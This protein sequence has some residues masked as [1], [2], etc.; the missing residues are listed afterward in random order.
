MADERAAGPATA[1]WERT[2]PF[3]GRSA[4][5]WGNG[6][7]EGGERL[8]LQCDRG[9]SARAQTR[10]C[11]APHAPGGGSPVRLSFMPATGAAVVA[12]PCGAGGRGAARE[13]GAQRRVQEEPTHWGAKNW[14]CARW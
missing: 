3:P 5:A 9:E 11:K 6:G 7:R 12:W 10:G 1:L 13:N 2:D 8:L 4:T 14:V